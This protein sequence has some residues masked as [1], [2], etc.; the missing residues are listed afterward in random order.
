VIGFALAGV[1]TV[2]STG[3][4]REKEKE[5]LFILGEF[6]AAIERYATASPGAQ[7]LPERLEEL[8]A[9]PRFPYIRRHLRRIYVDP[10]TGKAQWGLVTLQ[11]RIAGV[12]SLSEDQ[13]L[14]RTYRLATIDFAG[15][16][17]YSDWRVAYV[18][19]GQPGSLTTGAAA[20]SPSGVPPVVAMPPPSS[21]ERPNTLDRDVSS[22]RDR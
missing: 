9:D 6:H 17:K 10:M 3:V 5:L 12:H 20:T 8:V 13:P 22:M 11:G 18:P 15:A 16:Q 19:V 14:G 4:Q 7:A 1:A 2:W 21:S